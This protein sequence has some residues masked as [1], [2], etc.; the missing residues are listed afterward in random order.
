V[1]DASGRIIAQRDTQPRGDTYP[2]STWPADEVVIDPV[3]VQVPAGVAP[4]TYRIILG[5]YR[6]S[7]GQRLPVTA[8]SAA[9]PDSLEIGSVRV[10]P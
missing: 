9:G 6:P 2:T 3:N 4:G 8:S 10:R 1:L 7:D 5:L